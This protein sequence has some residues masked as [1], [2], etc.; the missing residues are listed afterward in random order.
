MFNNIKYIDPKLYLPKG[1]PDYN[2]SLSPS[3]CANFSSLTD[4]VGVFYSVKRI[5]N[6]IDNS[7][8]N[9][10]QLDDIYGFGKNVN[11]NGDFNI[12]Y[13]N[14][15]NVVFGQ[16]SFS[17]S[18]WIYKNESPLN[19]SIFSLSNNGS[20]KSCLYVE[21]DDIKFFDGTNTY[22]VYTLN[23][24]MFVKRGLKSPAH[25]VFGYNFDDEYV[26]IYIDGVEYS[27]NTV[28]DLDCNEFHILD[29]THFRNNRFIFNGSVKWFRS[30]DRLLSYAE[31]SSL[32]SE[33]DHGSGDG[34]TCE[35][36][37][38]SIPETLEDDTVYI[39]R[40]YPDGTYTNINL[41]ETSISS[42][43]F[44][45]CPMSINDIPLWIGDKI[46]NLKWIGEIG[47]VKIKPLSND[48]QINN[49]TISKFLMKDVEIVRNSYG[50][51]PVFMFNI[52][53]NSS[54][55]VFD[56]CRF[57]SVGCSLDDSNSISLNEAAGR[58]FLSTGNIGSFVIKNSII[59]NTN[60]HYNAFHIAKCN[61]VRIDNVKVYSST[62]EYSE[63]NGQK[64][65][66]AFC[67][68]F[69]SGDGSYV[70]SNYNNNRQYLS[71]E[72]VGELFVRNLSMMVKHSTERNLPGLIVAPCSRL[73]M[74]DINIDCSYGGDEEQ[75]NVRSYN[76]VIH[77]FDAYDYEVEN[78][79]VN[80]PCLSRIFYH[81]IV[82]FE[83][84]DTCEKNESIIG[85]EFY[86][87]INNVNIKIGSD[88]S[89]KNTDEE[90]NYVSD[91]AGE[92]N[93]D[94]YSALFIRATKQ[95]SDNTPSHQIHL[96]KNCSVTAL[97]S[98]AISVRGI[99]GSFKNIDGTVRVS[100]SNIDVKNLTNNFGYGAIDIWS[101]GEVNAENFVSNKSFYNN[102]INY[103]PSSGPVNSHIYIK[104]SNTELQKNDF[105]MTT[106]GDNSAFIYCP[107]MIVNNGFFIRGMQHVILPVSIKRDNGHGVSLKLSG[108]G[109]YA[110]R[111]PP[112][113]YKGIGYKLNQNSLMTVYF[114]IFE[115]DGDFREITKSG[116]RIEVETSSGIYSSDIDG[117]W[118]E[119][120]S[121]WGS[122]SLIAFKYELPVEV[123]EE[124]KVYVRVYYN[125]ETK[126]N[127]GLF[128]DP[129]IEWRNI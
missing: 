41:E 103:K 121:N 9:S 99:R 16:K 2:E 118:S 56:G 36:P 100:N 74:K 13:T 67:F 43:G 108:H 25:I 32:S 78:V 4:N 82:S 55:F 47:S 22:N 69:M 53:S 73:R 27:I 109:N 64:H 75:N 85:K 58:Y 23:N 46:N 63:S 51:N 70:F 111:F 113:P 15:Q 128:M 28:I 110:F 24:S 80:L 79:N 88:D 125:V 119:D 29:S 40:R 94:K 81:P 14:S 54:K 57:S 127:G 17:Y 115:Q 48:S 93:Y 39:I 10:P 60:T 34:S 21:N 126:S 102:M 44:L 61:N 30:Y 123:S 105:S 38:G 76:G 11:S 42:V 66:N 45:G 116:L 104:N 98:T 35:Y 84:K 120:S 62:G 117:M 3:D 106:Y 65:Y 8:L 101:N 124:E 96:I 50:S 90:R 77:I 49:A 33:F 122:V 5:D 7:V 20:T 87:I 114:S 59:V 26:V 129:K 107:N 89:D 72:L 91:R 12:L 86:H 112:N 1:Q 97:N 92:S 95:R 68:G 6:I 31:V 18:A 71:E 37:L 83:V 52:N 19:G